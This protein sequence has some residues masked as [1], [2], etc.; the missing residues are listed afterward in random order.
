MCVEGS[1]YIC[2]DKFNPLLFQPCP[3]VFKGLKNLEGARK[4]KV[5]TVKVQQSAYTVRLYSG[6]KPDGPFAVQ[7][8]LSACWKAFSVL[9]Y[10]N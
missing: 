10:F 8:N 7:S 4:G 1:V 6:K 9:V 3:H 5:T 2:A